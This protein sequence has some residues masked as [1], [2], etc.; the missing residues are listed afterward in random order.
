MAAK[1]SV[2]D[3]AMMALWACE[4]AGMRVEGRQRARGE[5]AER[6]GSQSR[7]AGGQRAHASDRAG[8]ARFASPTGPFL[9]SALAAAVLV[10]SVQACLASR[11]GQS[12]QGGR[13]SGAGRACSGEAAGHRRRLLSEWALDAAACPRSGLQQASSQRGP[14]LT[15]IRHE[16]GPAGAGSC[17]PRAERPPCMHAAF[18]SRIARNV[19]RGGRG[20]GCSK[21]GV[22]QVAHPCSSACFFLQLPPRARARR[23]PGPRAPPPAKS[24]A[25]ERCGG[26]RVASGSA[27]PRPPRR[28]G[29]PPS[30]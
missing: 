15:A 21:A 4:M 1:A 28:A 5:R 19:H 29:G 20:A 2:R 13:A 27:P 3:G 12:R 18:R 9:L 7:R 8:R 24:S 14:G 10:F 26:G 23:T 30:D 6:G 11:S 16:H 22:G 17:W 25:R